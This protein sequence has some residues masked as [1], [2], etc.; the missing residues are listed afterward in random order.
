MK[1]VQIIDLSTN[2]PQSVYE[3]SDDDFDILFP[4][5]KDM[6]FFATDHDLCKNVF[7]KDIIKRLESQKISEDDF[8]NRI[9]KVIVDKK[10][11]KGIQGTLI[12]ELIVNPSYFPNHAESDWEHN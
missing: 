3:I 9:Y 4:K 11:I 8:W 12:N 5:N 6:A 2:Y 10:T 1:N 7:E